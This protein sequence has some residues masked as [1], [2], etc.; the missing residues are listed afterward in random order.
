M[1]LRTLLLLLLAGTFAACSSPRPGA[2]SGASE[3]GTENIEEE[4]PDLTRDVFLRSI[5]IEAFDD[6][7]RPIAWGSGVELYFATVLTA[8]HVVERGSRF[9]F[10]QCLFNRNDKRWQ[11][12]S[13]PA[14]ILLLDRSRDL[15]VIR[16]P[17]AFAG[18]GARWTPITETPLRLGEIVYVHD[19][20]PETRGRIWSGRAIS[21]DTISISGRPGASGAGVFVLRNGRHE[22]AGVVVS[23]TEIP[24]QRTE[25][26]I[27][28]TGNHRINIIVQQGGESITRL[29]TSDTIRE[30]AA[31]LRP[32]K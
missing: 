11:Y 15:A 5:L 1:A 22:L 7:G 19:F 18:G 2:A 30:V 24:P 14:E 13:Y 29:A 10:W 32:V 6:Q 12:E 16:I 28:N 17:E 8:A 27:P 4:K 23:R 25:F 9:Q 31:S 21:V 3:T 26:T 20:A